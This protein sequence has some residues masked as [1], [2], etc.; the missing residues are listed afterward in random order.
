[1]QS[2][3]VYR[4]GKLIQDIPSVV[5]NPAFHDDHGEAKQPV[6]HAVQLEPGSLVAR[7]A[8]A[9]SV[10]VNSFHHQAV[11]Q[12]GRGRQ[13]VATAPDGVIEAVEDTSGQFFVGIQWHPERENNDFAKAIFKAFIDAA[14]R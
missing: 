9:T 7:L 8:G 1:A 3:N 2:L 11:A 6:L 4:G 10:E 13:A 12:A 5:P 14:R